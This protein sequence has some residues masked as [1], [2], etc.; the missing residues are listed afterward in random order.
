ME[1]VTTRFFR[2]GSWIGDSSNLRRCVASEINRTY[3]F[4]LAWNHVASKTCN[5]VDNV[6]PSGIIGGAV[7]KWLAGHG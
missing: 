7:Y 1:L 4:Q 3:H 2:R 6:M 5:R